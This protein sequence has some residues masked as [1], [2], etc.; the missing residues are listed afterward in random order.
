MS[1]FGRLV[2]LDGLRAIAALSVFIHHFTEHASKLKPEVFYAAPVS[3]I[4]DVF[5]P[6]KIG[7]SG[8]TLF[9]IISGFVILASLTRLRDGADFVVGRFSRLY[10]LFW[11]AVLATTLIRVLVGGDHISF[12]S[13]L[14]NLTMAPELF[15]APMIDGV[16][17][18]LIVELKFYF[19]AFLI[20]R[21]GLINRVEVVCAGGVILAVV[22]KLSSGRLISTT[23]FE[24]LNNLLILSHAALFTCGVMLFRL[25]ASGATRQRWLLLA[26]EIGRASCRERV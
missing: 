8:V 1:N 19:L 11:T 20:W 15:D 18:T 17:W 26:A 9:F 4:T 21:L 23:T 3:G 5:W 22:L 2:G 24:L 16:Y 13:F 25:H 12:G 10:P 14:A 6:F 7:A